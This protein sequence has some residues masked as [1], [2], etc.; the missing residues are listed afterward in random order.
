[1]STS[2]IKYFKNSNTGQLICEQTLISDIITNI[3]INYYDI[4]SRP[5]GENFNLT[6]FVQI[7]EKKWN[8]YRTRWDK[9]KINLEYYDNFNLIKSNQLLRKEKLEKLS[10]IKIK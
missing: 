6:G 1:M 9:T 8:L 2:I 4:Y 10:K 5:L 3:P 7:K